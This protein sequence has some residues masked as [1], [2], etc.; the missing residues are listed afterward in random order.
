MESRNGANQDEKAVAAVR[1]GLASPERWKAAVV[2]TGCRFRGSWIGGGGWTRQ[3]E[4]DAMQECPVRRTP[5]PVVADLMEALG[6]H[7]LQTA[8]DN[9]LGREGHGFP[10]MEL[11]VLRTKTDLAVGDGEN[12]V[13]RQGDAVDVP[14]QVAK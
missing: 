11:G 14:A 13:I 1:T 9:L 12:P 6:Q 5:Q 10:P 2:R 4:L 7:M 3:P 8:P